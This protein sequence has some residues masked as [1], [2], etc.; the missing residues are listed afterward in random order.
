MNSCVQCWFET[1]VHHTGNFM[2]N[3]DSLCSRHLDQSKPVPRVPS[4]ASKPK[5]KD[6]E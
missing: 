1:G 2:R 3:G 5:W 6:D 4:D